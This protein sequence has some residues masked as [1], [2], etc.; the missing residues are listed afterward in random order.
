MLLKLDLHVHTSH[1]QDALTDPQ[2]VA[3]IAKSRGL[4]GV[5]VTE[6]DLLMPLESDNI[7]IIP[8]IEVS[9]KEGHVL[10][11]GGTTPVP[12]GLEAKRT[13]ELLHE[14]GFLVVIPHPYDRSSPWVDP[15]RLGSSIDAIET[16]NSSMIPFGSCKKKAE[17]AARTLGLPM[18]AGSD[19]HIPSTIGDAYTLVETV[20]PTV[21]S[22]L[23]SIRSG[24]TTPCGSSMSLGN[25]IRTLRTTLAKSLSIL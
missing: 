10:G 16:I 13:I 2:A 23:E 6:H 25:R 1:S 7:L 3:E 8:G 15:L 14:H 24:K 4:D 19:S 5:A 12:K 9:S 20:A 22:V 21:E 18:V 17:N 11:L